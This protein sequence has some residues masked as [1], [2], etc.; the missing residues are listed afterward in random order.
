[1]PTDVTLS[2]QGACGSAGPAHRGHQ[3]YAPGC[4]HDCAS[5]IKSLGSDMRAIMVVASK[6]NHGGVVAIKGTLLAPMFE[7]CPER[8]L[9]ASVR[10][11]RRRKREA[12]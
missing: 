10:H 3:A 6:M 8:C 7:D 2:A 1:M 11:R 9:R 12:A 5:V 4:L